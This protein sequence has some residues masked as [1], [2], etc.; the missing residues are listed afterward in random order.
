MR[1]PTVV[2]LCVLLYACSSNSGSTS[3]SSP[4]SSS[5]Q[6]QTTLPTTNTTVVLHD[7]TVTFK[8]AQAACAGAIGTVSFSLGHARAHGADGVDL[9]ETSSAASGISTMVFTNHS[10][11]KSNTV[12][13]NG[14]NRS[15]T[16]PNGTVKKSGSVACVMAP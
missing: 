4:A 13:A 7:S 15:V 16:G 3:Q 1:T 11:G 10:S 2:M 14:H 6:A 12:V 5:T 8:A 9:N